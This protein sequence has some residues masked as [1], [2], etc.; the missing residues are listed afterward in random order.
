MS[1]DYTSPLRAVQPLGDGGRDSDTSR[2]LK[3]IFGWRNLKNE[4]MRTLGSEFRCDVGSLGPLRR[5]CVGASR[6][7]S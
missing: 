6:L 2:V 5:S 3:I 7:S 4:I 1:L